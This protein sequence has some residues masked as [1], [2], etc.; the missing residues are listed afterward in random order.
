MSLAKT[1]VEQKSL[2]TSTILQYLHDE[3]DIY[4]LHVACCV[5]PCLT[6][7]FTARQTMLGSLFDKMQEATKDHERYIRYLLRL[8]G[9]GYEGWKLAIVNG[10]NDSFW[11]SFFFDRKH[12]LHPRWIPALQDVAKRHQ[13]FKSILWLYE[14]QY[15]TNIPNFQKWCI[16]SPMYD[17][18][19]DFL[20]RNKMITVETCKYFLGYVA[21]QDRHKNAIW[22]DPEYDEEECHIFNIKNAPRLDEYIW[23]LHQLLII[24]QPPDYHTLNPSNY[25]TKL[26]FHLRLIRINIEY[27][28]LYDDL[29]LAWLLVHA[30]NADGMIDLYCKKWFRVIVESRPDIFVILKQIYDTQPTHHL[31]SLLHSL[32]LYRNEKRQVKHWQTKK[33]H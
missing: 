24:T 16:Q 21:A 12:M 8:F 18:L 22:Y 28:R 2:W 15:F 5:K 14:H 4:S 32:I 17:R 6:V 26:I 25:I 11:L 33:V 29:S 19:I 1:V 30:S 23:P 7:A 27:L 31:H 13:A 10:V 3:L 20:H 9:L